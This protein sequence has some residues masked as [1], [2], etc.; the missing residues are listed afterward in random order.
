[1]LRNFNAFVAVMSSPARPT[2]LQPGTAPERLIE[3]AAPSQESPP[4]QETSIAAAPS[5]AASEALPSF[6]KVT[7]DASVILS[8]VLLSA[9]GRH[10]LEAFG[11]EVNHVREVAEE[12]DSRPC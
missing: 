5:P 2:A 10:D 8:F 1:M 12:C 7:F 3:G 6:E 9:E 4:E 11:I